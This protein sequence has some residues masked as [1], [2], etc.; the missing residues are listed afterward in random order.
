MIFYF[1][2]V[3]YNNFPSVL[4]LSSFGPS[5]KL[6]RINSQEELDFHDTSSGSDQSEASG[7]ESMGDLELDAGRGSDQTFVK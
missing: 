6:Q 5:R 7:L 1:F 2:V 4:N 3:K